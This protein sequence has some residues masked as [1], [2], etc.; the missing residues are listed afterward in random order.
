MRTVRG[1]LSWICLVV[2][3]G[4]AGAASFIVGNPTPSQQAAGVF[5][6]NVYAATAESV[7][8]RIE[9]HADSAGPCGAALF[10]HSGPSATGPWT[11]V[12]SAARSPGTGAG[13]LDS[14]PL[15]LGVLAGTYYLVGLGMDCTW[16]LRAMPE[17]PQTGASVSSRGR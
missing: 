6:G 9:V 2:C 16:G 14:G 15:Q 10:L 17:D 13:F 4:P 8:T 12:W 11:P 1:L 5:H 3:S 7:L